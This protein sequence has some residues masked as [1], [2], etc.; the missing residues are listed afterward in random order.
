MLTPIVKAQRA[1]LSPVR[2]VLAVTFT[3][4][5]NPDASDTYPPPHRY[6]LHLLLKL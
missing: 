4:L 1:P 6:R 3:L 2:I 5:R